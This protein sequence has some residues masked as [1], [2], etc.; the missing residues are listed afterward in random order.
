VTS[1]RKDPLTSC[2]KGHAVVTS[3]DR[4]SITVTS[5]D[6]GPV[7]CDKLAIGWGLV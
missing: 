2:D 5:Y 1:S 7:S 3:Y 4:D 6:N